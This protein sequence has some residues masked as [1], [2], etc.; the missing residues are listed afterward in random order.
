MTIGPARRPDGIPSHD[1]GGR[2]LPQA[3]G[4]E[5]VSRAEVPESVRG[6]VEF[7]SACPTPATV[8]RKRLA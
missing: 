3:L 5:R 1:D 6:S 8:M 4:F 7:Q 2:I